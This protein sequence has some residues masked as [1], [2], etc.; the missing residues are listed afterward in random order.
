MP[1][2][3]INISTE[4]ED[5]IIRFIRDNNMKDNELVR[6][7]LVIK[8]IDLGVA[9]K[10]SSK[11]FESMKQFCDMQNA[12]LNEQGLPKPNASQSNKPQ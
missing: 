6:Q 12:L 1:K 9:V 10:T 8:F 7:R 11:A 2:Y 4:T 3:N 5:R